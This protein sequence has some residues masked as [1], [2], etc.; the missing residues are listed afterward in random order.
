MS[1]TSSSLPR[2]QFFFATQLSFD[3]PMPCI[4][5]IIVQRCREQP[6]NAIIACLSCRYLMPGQVSGTVRKTTF[7]GG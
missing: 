1:V 3:V 7:L 5:N 4:R 2:A 6:W